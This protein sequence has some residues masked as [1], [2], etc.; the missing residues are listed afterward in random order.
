MRKVLHLSTSFLLVQHVGPQWKGKSLQA[1]L[2]MHIPKFQ[3][4]MAEGME[5]GLISPS[6][7]PLQCICENGCIDSL[8]L[9]LSYLKPKHRMES[10]RQWMWSWGS[11]HP[12]VEK[13]L[14][15]RKR[16]RGRGRGRSGDQNKFALRNCVNLLLSNIRISSCL[17][18]PRVS[19]S[20][21]S[22]K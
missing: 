12:M 13:V 20:V 18:I 21:I 9:C 8:L 4:P 5:A 22:G 3:L 2:D 16:G 10:L 19:K 1:L 14:E 11:W 7:A 15:E 17:W 6:G